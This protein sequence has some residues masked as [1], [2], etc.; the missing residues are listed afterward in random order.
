MTDLTKLVANGRFHNS[1]AQPVQLVFLQAQVAKF[2]RGNL[3]CGFKFRRCVKKIIR[4]T[5]RF[6]LM[7]QTTSLLYVGSNEFC[8]PVYTG[9]SSGCVISHTTQPGHS[10][11][12]RR[13]GYC[14]SWEADS[15]DTRYIRLQVI[16][17]PKKS[18]S[19]LPGK[20]QTQAGLF[21]LEI[22][23]PQKVQVAYGG[24]PLKRPKQV[25][26][27][28]Q[29]GAKRQGNVTKKSSDVTITITGERT[30]ESPHA[31]IARTCS[32]VECRV[33]YMQF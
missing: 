5:L 14:L 21:E 13:I 9:I 24:Q 32:A 30:A 28:F 10:F 2:R 15:H 17:Y 11:L 8:V 22:L 3:Y 25:K 33:S 27:Q 23:K 18:C 4:D 1:A 7:S 31:L 19:Q 26:M 29:F 6:V 16:H 20:V 12:G